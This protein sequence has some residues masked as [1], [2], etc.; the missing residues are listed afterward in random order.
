[1]AQPCGHI[2]A[3][4]AR[5]A[6]AEELD[7]A[8][9]A[10]MRASMLTQKS[11][12]ALW[13]GDWAGAEQLAEASLLDCTRIR[14]RYLAMMS[15]ALAAYARWRIDGSDAQVARIEETAR[16]FK[17]PGNSFQRTSLV[18]GWLA[19]VKSRQG[20]HRAA[21]FH[22]AEAVRRVREG[23]DRLGE[24]MAW[25]A[26]A[27]SAQAQG[28]PDRADRYLTLADHSAALRK[29]A[30]EQA[31]N[32]FC[33]AQLAEARGDHALARAEREQS[34]SQLAALGIDRLATL[35]ASH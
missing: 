23:G 8:A 14:T 10:N 22:A 5:Y 3:S 17:A 20:D 16:W 32:R 19:D 1:M 15:H 30:R 28:Q 9:L 7:A 29:S 11:A 24:G 33:A 18:F 2:A 35:A 31:M 6:E 26:M 25:R 34:A 27:R 13:V 12:I 21:R 4:A